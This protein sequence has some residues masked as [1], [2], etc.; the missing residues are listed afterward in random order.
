MESRLNP[1]GA[2]QIITASDAYLTS[3]THHDSLFPGISYHLILLLVTCIAVG[4][5]R[6]YTP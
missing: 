1:K 2:C 6:E 4:S 3:S 5:S